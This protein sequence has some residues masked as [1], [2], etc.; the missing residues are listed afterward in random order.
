MS[1]GFEPLGLDHLVLRVRD[2]AASQRFYIDVL[3]C[4]LDHVN[5]PIALVQLRFGAQLIDLLPGERAEGGG[6]D[7]FC[8]S[9]RCPDL[10][11]VRDGLRARGVTVDGD[12]VQRRGAFGTGPSLY[13]QDPDGYR[14][15]LKPR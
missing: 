1:R 4:T 13:V 7:H 3:G 14:I 10:A 12:V 9:I 2:Q 15:E 8:L 11:A 5:E 6:L